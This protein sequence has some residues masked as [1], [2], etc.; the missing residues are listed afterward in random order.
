MNRTALININCATGDREYEDNAHI[1]SSRLSDAM[2]RWQS[3]NTVP[4]NQFSSY[5]YQF[6]NRCSVCF[7][8]WCV[9]CWRLADVERWE[10]LTM[11]WVV[12][13]NWETDENASTLWSCKLCTFLNQGALLNAYES[14]S[15]ASSSGCNP[16]CVLMVYGMDPMKFNCQRVFNLLCIYG[17]VIKVCWM[18]CQLRD[19]FSLSVYSV[20]V[21]SLDMP[22]VT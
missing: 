2:H 20:L 12:V 7:S 15:V 19:D 13:D 11:L 18:A 16:S 21:L 10:C 3:A 4:V 9:E 6:V 1:V 8:M 22:T 17:N 5:W 14:Q